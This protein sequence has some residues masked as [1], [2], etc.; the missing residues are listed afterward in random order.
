MPLLHRFVA[1]LAL[2]CI[3][4][5]FVST[6]LVELFGSAVS[7]ATIKALIVWP[8]LFILVP[9][10]AATGATGF[11]LAQSRT[12]P[13]VQRKKT[14]MPF[15]AL[16]GLL[17]LIPCAVYLDALAAAG[18]FD[19]RFYVVQGV[20]LLAGAINLILMSMNMRDGL[21]LRGKARSN[22]RVLHQSR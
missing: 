18:T 22:A 8:G 20:E 11:A 12:G 9:A 5:F 21:R 19:T 6:V 10:I 2:L 17:V 7:V 16:N 3:A 1:T 15:I 14:R 13:P 4:I